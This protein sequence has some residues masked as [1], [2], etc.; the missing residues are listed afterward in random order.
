MMQKWLN[1]SVRVFG[2]GILAYFGFNVFFEALRNQQVDFLEAVRLDGLPSAILGGLLALA[3]LFMAQRLA[4]SDD[5]IGWVSRLTLG[6]VMLFAGIVKL[7]EPGG[8][9]DSILAY[10]L[11]ISNSIATF[12]GYAL[13]AFEVAIGLMLIIGLGVRLAAYASGALMLVF[14]VAIAQVWARGYSIDCGCF[15]SGGALDPEGR[16]LRYTLEII[17]DFIFTGMAAVLVL[18]PATPFTLLP[19]RVDD[20][21]THNG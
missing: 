1:I 3:A 9:R 18:N 17:R 14:I 8:A 20:E 16:H 7:F 10:R 21:G 4:N 12:L 5:N 11:G 6:F 19:A 2:T 15:G 13:P